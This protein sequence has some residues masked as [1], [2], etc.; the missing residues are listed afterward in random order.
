[1]GIQHYLLQMM[2]LML[3]PGLMVHSPVTDSHD[4][5]GTAHVYLLSP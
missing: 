4:Q 1:M 2:V 3:S 5:G